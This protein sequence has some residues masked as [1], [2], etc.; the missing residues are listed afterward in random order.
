MNEIRLDNFDELKEIV[1]MDN[2]CEKDVSVVGF[3]EDIVYLIKL[4]CED[5]NTYLDNVEIHSWDHDGYDKEFVLTLD[6]TGGIWCEPFYRE[7]EKHTGY[8]TLDG[9]IT[10]VLS[11]VNSKCLKNILSEEI[12]EI[13]LDDDEDSEY[14]E[15]E[16]PLCKIENDDMA[17]I[18]KLDDGTYEFYYENESD[19]V[20]YSTS[21]A[22]NNLD[23][24][25][26]VR[27][28]YFGI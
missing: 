11:D 26:K 14:N 2:E 9:D 1:L 10:Y 12:V 15:C 6:S 7:C 5:E 16:C 27:N 8:F 18:D 4:L 20:S 13:S 23:D 17:F 21:F 28:K 3:Y 24:V 22:S 25:I 19:S